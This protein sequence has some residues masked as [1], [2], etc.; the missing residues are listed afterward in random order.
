[1]AAAVNDALLGLFHKRCHRPFTDHPLPEHHR[2]VYLVRN[3]QDYAARLKSERQSCILRTLSNY[4]RGLRVF[5]DG[6]A[7]AR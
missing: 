1:M 2:P 7:Q 4:R 6:F 3:F 5:S